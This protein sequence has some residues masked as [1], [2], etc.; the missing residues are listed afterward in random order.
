[1]SAI[2]IH[3]MN[4]VDCDQCTSGVLLRHRNIRDLAGKGK[5]VDT[6]RLSIIAVVRGTSL[7][8]VIV[9]STIERNSIID[10]IVLLLSFYIVIAY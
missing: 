6:G 5:V 4:P 2:S 10:F 7:W 9:G 1:M 3:G 8:S